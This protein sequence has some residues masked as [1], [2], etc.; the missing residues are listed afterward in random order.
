MLIGLAMALG[1]IPE[2]M[3]AHSLLAANGLPVALL[4]R[5]FCQFWAAGWLVDH[6][7]IATLFYPI[8]FQA[9]V[10]QRFPFLTGHYRW[11]YPP[12][13]ALLMA[14]LGLVPPLAAWIIGMLGGIAL[15]VLALGM[16]FGRH[17]LALT[18]L[19]MIASPVC[20]DTLLV[21]Q[22]AFYTGALMVLGFGLMDRRPI[23]AGIALGLLTV[24]P[25]LG[26][27]VPVALIAAGAWRSM[28][29]ALVSGLAL[30]SLAAIAMPD[31][32]P[33]F[34]A[35]TMPDM[36]AYLQRPYLPTPSQAYMA[37]PF[38]AAEGLHLPRRTVWLVQITLSVLAAAMMGQL[39]R[40]PIQNSARH[41][42][43]LASAAF[44]L[45]A[46]PYSHVYDAVGATALL[47]A[48]LVENHETIRPWM[49]GLALAQPGWSLILAIGFHVPVFAW[50]VWLAI[51][52]SLT[53]RLAGS[54]RYGLALVVF[55][56]R[57]S[58]WAIGGKA[59][60]RQSRLS[61]SLHDK[62][63]PTAAPAKS[64]PSA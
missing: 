23:W 24:K 3:I 42:R 10:V 58:R 37:S 21:G 64:S 59:R 2:V 57:A 52:C 7:R 41:A 36:T 4:K 48:V 5:D 6:G 22:N 55:T 51:G 12:G 45:V 20:W 39:W 62:P 34:I 46:T 53:Y 43:I 50:I 15:L 44:C 33:L 54:N 19:I 29:A 31:A 28:I 27:L 40:I 30:A 1:L 17:N 38:Y 25:P 32:W 35:H 18:T 9:W 61:H 26:L 56:S 13:M 60:E 63:M 11:G 16:V 14:P 49:L 8:R 47:C